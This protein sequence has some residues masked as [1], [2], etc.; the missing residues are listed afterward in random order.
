MKHI[1]MKH[2]IGLLAAS[3]T[4]NA[5]AAVG[6]ISG[7]FACRNLQIF[8]VHGETQLEVRR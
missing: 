8:L 3:T 4:M 2:L 1:W 7:P 5:G 6:T